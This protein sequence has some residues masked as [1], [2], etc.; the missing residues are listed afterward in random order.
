[1][2]CR[3]LTV[4]EKKDNQFQVNYS[5][6]VP[7][8]TQM[9][10]FL[11]VINQSN[12]NGKQGILAQVQTGQG[13]SVIIAMVAA[14][15]SIMHG[16]KVD[17]I[18]SNDN[19]AQRDW[20]EMKLFYERLGIS[21]TYY[22]DGELTNQWDVIYCT[23]NNIINFQSKMYQNIITGNY[24][25]KLRRNNDCFIGDEVDAFLANPNKLILD[26]SG[27]KLTEI[28]FIWKFLYQNRDCLLYTSPSPRDRQKSRMPSSA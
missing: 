1:M 21:S 26:I 19:L 15:Y 25:P 8:H 22:S 17:I 23:I 18:T 9:I 3:E 13:K 6:I 16:E 2:I 28:N 12:V 10:T 4:E 24:D 14:Y 20:E 5:R 11:A 7:H 27:K